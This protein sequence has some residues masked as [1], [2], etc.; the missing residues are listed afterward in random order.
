MNPVQARAAVLNQLK[1]RGAKVRR[2]SLRLEVGDLFW[3]ADPRIVG[4]GERAQVVLEVGCW[5]PQL[6][7]EPDGGAVDCPLLV[8]VAIA[9][10]AADVETLVARLQGIASLDVLAARLEEFPGVM[11]DRSLRDLLAGA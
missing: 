9:D 4:T 8:E 1:T 5:T 11:V 10:P 6:P 7:P 2:G 3:Y